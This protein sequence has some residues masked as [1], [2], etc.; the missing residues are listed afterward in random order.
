[1]K[2]LIWLVGAVVAVLVAATLLMK[3]STSPNHEDC[4]FKEYK[5]YATFTVPAS[6][7]EKCLSELNTQT[8]GNAK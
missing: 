1:M 6:E 4:T 8:V 5:P 2:P 7:V 3:G